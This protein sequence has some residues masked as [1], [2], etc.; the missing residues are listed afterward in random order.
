[1]SDCSEVKL[2]SE[3]DEY[4]NILK[5]LESKA[6]RNTPDM[7]DFQ[8]SR[9]IFHHIDRVHDLWKTG[10]TVPVHM[11]VGLTNYCQHKCPWCY[12][13]YDQAGANSK[14]SGSGDP[15]KKAINADDKLINAVLDAQ[16]MGLKAVTLVGDG[17]PTL[18]KKF[19]EYSY[20]LKE[21]GLDLGLF[22]NM[23][24]NK[25]EV[26]QAFFDNFFFV[27]CS[28]DSANAEYHKETHG[29][30][31]FDLII[32][33]IKRVVA[34]K[35]D[36]K[37][38]FP[39]IGIQY[40]TSRGNYKDLPYAVQLYK[41]IGV[42]Y[43]TIKPMYKNILNPLHKENDLTFE[44]VQPMMKRAE[45]VADKKFKVYAKYSQFIETLG[46]QTND[47]IYYKKCYATPISPY[48]DE[49]GNVEMCGN[50]KGRGFTLG[51]IYESSFKEIWESQHRQD[52]LNKIDL[53]KCPAG[54]KLDPLNKV[55]W[56]TFNPDEKRV[57]PNFT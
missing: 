22:S 15:S 45:A 39:I 4:G 24:F 36:K 12:I 54:C 31:D 26:F 52:C 38:L 29:S 7:E 44:E 13:N 34:L 1:M 9:K 46:R 47:G 25:E 27:R 2:D 40:V 28:L 16:K 55:L 3:Y 30:D 18:H 57:H 11:T 43:L 37:T 48:L 6:F 41:E 23:S 14:R 56:D 21:S 32:D 20:K 49:N 10:D 19:A 42:D 17:E 53:N 51:N 35:K 33:N 50:L 8:D 5:S